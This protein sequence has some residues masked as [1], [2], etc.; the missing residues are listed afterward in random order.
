MERN[1]HQVVL[2]DCFLLSPQ[3]ESCPNSSSPDRSRQSQGDSIVTAQQP[4][5]N[6]DH[7]MARGKLFLP[8]IAESDPPPPHQKG[9]PQQRHQKS[10]FCPQPKS[11]G[12]SKHPPRRDNMF[13]CVAA[14]NHSHN[15]THPCLQGSYPSPHTTMKNLM[16]AF[17]SDS[18]K[19]QKSVMGPNNR[20]LS[21]ERLRRKQRIE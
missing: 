4:R 5:I 7:P 9:S 12:S 18:H 13:M 8:K 1:V 3:F 10:L 17:T 6:Q 2:L 11:G 19:W 14:A 20:L 16:L 15:P 21:S